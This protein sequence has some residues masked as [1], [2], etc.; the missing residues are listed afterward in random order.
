MSVIESGA[1]ARACCA[2]RRFIL[3]TIGMAL[4]GG[5]LSQGGA[6]AQ[7]G[8]ASS[9]IVN[10]AIPILPGKTTAAR[11]FLAELEGSRRDAYHRAD[12]AIGVERELWFLQPTPTGDLLLLY[13]EG[14]DLE[15]SFVEFIGSQDPLFVWFKRQLLEI[16]GQ[17]WSKPP[18]APGSELLSRFEANG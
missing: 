12:R 1:A 18:Q 9:D 15:K 14:P 16:T 4:A 5:L 11:A 17:D 13:M 8:K 10:L 6:M 2:R 7:E 3:A